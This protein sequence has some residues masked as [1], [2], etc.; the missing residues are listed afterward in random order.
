MYSEMFTKLNSKNK[1]EKNKDNEESLSIKCIFPPN[2]GGECDCPV[3][4]GKPWTG[5]CSGSKCDRSIRRGT[6]RYSSC[7][8]RRV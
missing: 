7:P 1:L 3:Y 2:V 8:G 5:I 6:R 4:R